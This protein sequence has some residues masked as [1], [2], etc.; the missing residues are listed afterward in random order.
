[1]KSRPPS[2]EGGRILQG[3]PPVRGCLHNSSRRSGK[4]GEVERKEVHMKVGYAVS[5]IMEK[6]IVSVEANAPLSDAMRTMVEHNIGSVLVTREGSMVGIVT[7]RDFL[8]KLVLGKEYTTLKVADVMSSP[9]LTI[10]SDAAIGE[11]ADLMAERNIRRL[12]VTEKGKIL[13]IITERDVIRA[14]LDVFR[15][16]SDAWV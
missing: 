9:L 2:V 11:A 7:E 15:K 5:S 14:T 12:L 4:D 3:L 6:D 13:G 8:R 10:E 16:L 1:M